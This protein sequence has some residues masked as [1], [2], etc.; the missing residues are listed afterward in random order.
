MLIYC[1]ALELTQKQ[2]RGYHNKRT[3][4]QRRGAVLLVKGNREK[5]EELTKLISQKHGRILNTRIETRGK[6]MLTIHIKHM[7]ALSTEEEVVEAI[8]TVAPNISSSE[9]RVTMRNTLEAPRRRS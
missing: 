4:N 2:T 3:K 8:K 1:E 5:A 7:D 9:I 6:K